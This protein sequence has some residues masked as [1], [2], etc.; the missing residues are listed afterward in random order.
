MPTKD[1]SKVDRARQFL[2]FDALKG[3][4]EACEK[5]SEL[6]YEKIEFSDD[7]NEDLNN[8]LSK[9]KIGELVSIIYYKDKRYIKICG[10]L[11]KIDYTYRYI[12][13][14]K[15]KINIDDIYEIIL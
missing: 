3:F 9:L 13:I 6:I 1:I 7:K 10:M 8:K 4:R 2:P 12:M 5:E 11:S 14:V 15:E